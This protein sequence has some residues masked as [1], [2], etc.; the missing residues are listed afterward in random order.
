MKRA[1]NFSQGGDKSV[2]GGDSN[3]FG[4]GGQA[5][6]G[7]DYPFMG[8][9][10]PHPP[11][12]WQPWTQP[13]L[14]WFPLVT[15]SIRCISLVLSLL[16]TKWAPANKGFF[17]GGAPAKKKSF[18]REALANNLL[19]AG[20]PPANKFLFAGRPPANNLFLKLKGGGYFSPPQTDI[21]N[22]GV[23]CIENMLFYYLTF[24]IMGLPNF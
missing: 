20:G 10:S 5:L 6:M 3:F 17:A 19:F 16:L 11:H 21:A 7:G 23:F 13:V 14:M 1:E 4:W 12:V 18:A 9:G 2:H 24:H 8:G 22:Y 15:F